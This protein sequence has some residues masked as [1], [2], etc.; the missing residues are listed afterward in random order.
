MIDETHRAD[1]RSWV[2]SAHD[3]GGDFPI[4]NLP[5]GIVRHGSSDTPLAAV[6]IGDQVMLLGVAVR[7]GLLTGLAAE[8]AAACAGGVLNPLMALGPNARRALRAG[9]VEALRHDSET[10]RRARSLR[11]E[12][13][14]NAADLEPLVPADV[15][16]YSDFYASVHHATNLGSMRRF[17][18]DNAPLLPNYSVLIG[19]HG[20]R[21]RSRD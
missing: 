17:G 19:Y 7:R 9:L 10:G 5:L 1:L 20:V 3:P 13:L 2:D 12:L 14:A 6:A 16:D 21:H 15:G 4:Q 11:L 8:A 18:P